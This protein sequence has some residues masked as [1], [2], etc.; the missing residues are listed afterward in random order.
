MEIVELAKADNFLRLAPGTWL[1]T[2]G[3]GASVWVA[4]GG[5]GARGML[6]DHAI[7]DDGT[8]SPSLVCPVEC[9]WHVSGRLVGWTP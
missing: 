5:C 3:E 1:K 4:C 2:G 7:A 6:S 9:G 8:V